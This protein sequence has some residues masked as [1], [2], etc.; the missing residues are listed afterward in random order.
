M[1]KISLFISPVSVPRAT[2]FGKIKDCKITL[3]CS[4]GCGVC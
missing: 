1:Q 2:F 4:V 3:T